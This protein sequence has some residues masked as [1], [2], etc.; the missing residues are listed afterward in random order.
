VHRVFT[1]IRLGASLV[2]SSGGVRGFANYGAALVARV[3]GLLDLLQR[4][5][6]RGKKTLRVLA[7]IYNLLAALQRPEG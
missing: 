6:L 5:L 4:M 7:S 2:A 1:P 3:E